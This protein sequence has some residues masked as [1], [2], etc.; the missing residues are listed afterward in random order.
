[1]CEC[2]ECVFASCV[3]C[4]CVRVVCVRVRVCVDGSVYK[5]V[6]V[7]VCDD[8]CRESRQ[9]RSVFSSLACACFVLLLLRPPFVFLSFRPLFFCTLLGFVVVVVVFVV[10]AAAAAAAAAVSVAVVC[11]ELWTMR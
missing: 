5:S 4:V 2:M 3:R 9:R 7:C 6:C 8:S 10:V 1:M 11:S